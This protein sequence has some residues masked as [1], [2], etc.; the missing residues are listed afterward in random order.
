MTKATL[1][2]FFKPKSI[3]VVGASG[4]NA[5]FGD[6]VLWNLRN[7]GATAKI[8]A[9][10]P[11]HSEVNGIPCVPSL[12]DMPE[13]P[14]LCIICVR[15]Q[16]AAPLLEECVRLGVPAVTIVATGFAETHEEEGIALQAAL[17]AA[18]K[19]AS[20]TRVIGPNTIGVSSFVTHTVSTATG[21]MPGVVP[22]GPVAIVSKSGGISSALLARGIS[23]GL[24]FCYKV[25]IGNEMDVSF[26]E[27]LAYMA[28]RDEAR[29]VVCYM[30]GVRDLDDLRRGIAACNARG[31]PVIFIKGGATSAGSRAAASHTGKLT[32]DN[33]I[34]RGI[35]A[36]FGVIE[37]VSID[38]A[39]T[40]AALFAKHGVARG[41]TVGGMGQGGGL[42]VMLADMF[43]RAGLVAPVPSAATQQIMREA[44]VTVTPNN[45]FD[46]GGVYLSGDG[47]EL[48]R[49]LR[50][51]SE[52]PGIGAMIILETATQRERTKAIIPAIIS[53]TANLS[54]PVVILSYDNPGSA[55]HQLLHDANLLVFGNPDTGIQAI[56]TWLEYTPLEP[57]AEREGPRDAVRAQAVQARLRAAGANA[58]RAVLEDAGKAALAD[59]GVAAPAECAVESVE[60]A[61]AAA[62]RIGYPVAMK[63]LSPNMLH[64][65][66]GK[67][68][69][70]GINDAAGVRAA[71]ARLGEAAIA[72]AR[73]LVQKMA[74]CGTEFLVGAV[75]DPELGL[76]LAIGGG[77][78]NVESRKDT[79]F[80]TLPVTRAE[81]R[82]LLVRLPELQGEQA[83]R[84]DLDALIETAAGIASFLE[85]AGAIIDELDVNPVIVGAPGEGAVAVDALIILSA[86]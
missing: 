82:R 69:L 78:A 71:Y 63:I 76:A 35:A 38:H 81:L 73:V 12:S 53:A 16:L 67:G 49:A 4:S 85:D 60:A 41:K 64:R 8:T 32:G 47:T 7:F 31:K 80:C 28:E 24:G 34:W 17:D 26:G 79:V 65:H 84:V 40:T 56:K 30:E 13:R 55:A 70:L 29:I 33:A 77:G 57:A 6:T 37:A 5:G 21:N 25:A 83:G 36:Q 54:K 20:A 61:V 23:L 52:E 46:T 50:A 3:A 72:D 44:L 27:V 42:T 66:V 10:H 86:Q 22:A 2:P 45:P 74:G 9:I 18:H 75:R 48:P 43:A 59:Y 11:R 68:V 58:A 15:R 51:L 1:D 14:D 62:D 19:G 39:L